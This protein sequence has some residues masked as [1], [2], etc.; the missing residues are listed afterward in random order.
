[1]KAKI[2]SFAEVPFLNSCYTSPMLEE[3]FF[4]IG[5]VLVIAAVLSMIVFRLRQPLIIAYI[6]TGIIA[7]PGLLALTHSQEVFE[8]FSQ[9]GVAF[10]LFTVGLGLNWKSVKDV[11]GIA[12]ATGVGQVLFTSTAIFFISVLL[13]FD[14]LTGAYLG[15]AFSFSSTIIIVKLL[16]D[17]EDLDTL[18]GRISVGFLL[19][20]DF[21][22]MLILLILSAIGSGTSL[23]TVLLETLAK[24]VLLVPII[25]LISTKL[26]PR[27]LK[28]VAQSQE[29]LFIFAIAWCFLVAGVLTFFGFGVE[30]GAL[31]AG[32]ML[33]SSVYYR[34]INSRVRPLRDFFLVLFFIVLGTRL[35]IDNLASSWIPSMIFA[36]FILLCN[37]FISMFIMRLL[38]YHP[39][40]GFLCGTTV[41]QISEF[42]FI[43]LLV[44]VSLGHL[45]QS[46]LTLATTVGLITIAA[47]SYLIEHNERIYQRLHWLLRWFEPASS[48]PSE[49]RREHPATEVLLFGFHRTGAELLSTLKT[50]KRPYLVVDFN[51]M[52][53]RELAE[54]GEPHV[55]GDVGDENFLEEIQTDK[56]KLIISTIPDF[57]VSTAL[58]TFLKSRQYQGVSIV[59][60][61]SPEEAKP[62]YDLGAT[63][64]IIPSILSGKKF[65]EL[66]KK[67]KTQKRAW[68]LTAKGF[69]SRLSR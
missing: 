50:L 46:I 6:L 15:V 57:V 39:R 54:R 5:V 28:Y 62:C 48:L 4:Q 14:P 65:S 24:V 1:M 10:L 8:S 22:A 31:I 66:L 61:H 32:I 27:V 37:P 17:K 38:G 53:V 55:Y 25:W 43:V 3:L 40:T 13:G 19:I 59:S 69:V 64:V 44:G 42:S 60:V 33:S 68:G 36:L 41:A 18:Y 12:L 67:S 9:I 29:L 56:S 63:Y 58:L 11:G 34:E 23:Q 16:M 26:L 7:G 51:P 21:I 52:A 45:D 47:S 20:Q 2:A 35:G 49:K 30:L